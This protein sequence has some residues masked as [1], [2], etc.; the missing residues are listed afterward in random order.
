M[1][2]WTKIRSALSLKQA[3]GVKFPSSSA[4]FWGWSDTPTTEV[5]D[6]IGDGTN[7]DVLM[8]PIRW[9]QRAFLE[10]PVETVD[11]TGEPITDNEL[12]QLLEA[13]TPF[14]SWEVLSA[15]TVLS[16]S[17]DG[18]A[19]W[20]A[21]ESETDRGRIVELWYAPHMN[22]APQWPQ[23]DPTKFI[24]HYDYSVAGETQ[25]ILPFGAEDDSDVPSGISIVPGLRVIQFR[26]GIDPSNLRLGLS[27]LKGLLREVWTDNEA[28]R[29]TA[30]LLRNNGVPGVVI[31]PADKDVTI[32]E[33]EAEAAKAKIEAQYTGLN[34]GRPLVMLGATKIDQFGFS[35]QELDLS[36]LRNISEERV[37]AALGVQSAV[38]GFGSGLQQTK[39]GATMDAMI[40]LSWINGVIPMQ[41]IIGGEMSRT[42]APAFDAA[43]TLFNNNAVEALR[44]NE[45]TK[46]NRL[47]RLWRDGVITR[48]E[49]RAP[50]GFES[51][52]AD[53]VYLANVVA[54]GFIPQGKRALEAPEQPADVTEAE[55]Q[56][57]EAGAASNGN[58]GGDAD[59][60]RAA[61]DAVRKALPEYLVTAQ[62]VVVNTKQHRHSA[63]EELIL[64]T[65]Q[66]PRSTAPSL[67]AMATSLDRIKR[68]AAPKF[69]PP[70]LTVFDD[71]GRSAEQATDIV[72]AANDI[73]LDETLPSSGE[74][75][76]ADDGGETK[77]HDPIDA[78]LADQIAELVDTEAAQRALVKTLEDGYLV[79]ASDVV[80]AIVDTLGVEFELS[81]EAQQEILKEGGLRA[82][83]IDLDEQTKEAIFDGLAEAREQGMTADN[84]ARFIRERVE[85]GPWRDATTRA[86]VIARTEGANA[87]N[88]STIGVAKTMP[89]TEHMMVFDN[90]SGFDDRI[91]SQAN[92]SV[93][94]IEQSEAI[95]LAHPN[96][97][98]SFVPVNSLLMDE[99]G[100]SGPISRPRPEDR[101]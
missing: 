36:P 30:S 47:G 44:E 51:K 48:A 75:E 41:R 100:L 22:M 89:E 98:R 73:A 85:A 17:V 24:T 26:E 19:Y 49:A 96:C 91:C 16:L 8:T 11:E 68:D 28:A 1:T 23:D 101:P 7:S 3:P 87:A 58:G 13:P 27:P 2:I 63:A 62:G 14:Y 88:V 29:F 94:T 57:A 79:V 70:L 99:M 80:D 18:N 33:E 12:L 38:V 83:L 52:P 21:A 77:Q 69:V 55:A 61:L 76:R 40:R 45:D 92:G 97:T 78:V 54:F 74:E 84:L 4:I 32:T 15:G 25:H 10:A 81:D 67:N 37:T 5:E 43:E 60:L 93:I 50:L 53:E 34:R 82:G 46:A 9:L 42:L 6:E 31:S 86:K 20:I 56:A 59:E 66:R 90:R 72:L 95:G 65:A 64:E 71:L 35:P 39:V